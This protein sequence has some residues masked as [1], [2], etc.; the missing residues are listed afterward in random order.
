MLYSIR[1]EKLPFSAPVVAGGRPTYEP[2]IIHVKITFLDESGQQVQATRPY[3][4][5]IGVYT[6]HV[7]KVIETLEHHFPDC[8]PIR[9]TYVGNTRKMLPYF[10]SRLLKNR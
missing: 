3:E 1:W 2:N 4:Q 8:K 7:E 10:E 6:N 9:Y 5:W